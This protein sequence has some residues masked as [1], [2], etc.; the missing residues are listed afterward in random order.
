MET[1]GLRSNLRKHLR[2]SLMTGETGVHAWENRQRIKKPQ[3]RYVKVQTAKKK[4]RKERKKKSL[5]G[6]IRILGKLA[7]LHKDK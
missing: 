5:N 1:I 2:L 4:K 3:V 7:F 6:M